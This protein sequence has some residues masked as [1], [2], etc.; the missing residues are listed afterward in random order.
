LGSFGGIGRTSVVFL[1]KD[2][3]GGAGE[4]FFN[5]LLIIL[6]DSK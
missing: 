5:G 4:F 3:Y 1:A 6:T 2:K